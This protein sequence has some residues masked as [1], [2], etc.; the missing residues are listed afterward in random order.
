M[1]TETKIRRIPLSV[2]DQSPICSGRSAADAIAETIQLAKLC[3][4]WGYHRYWVAEHHASKGLAGCSPEVLLARLGVETS[5]IRIGSGGVMLPHYSPYKVAENFKLLATM[6]PG[7]VD[8][9]VGRAPGSSQY[10]SAALRYGSG[11]D[12]DHFPQ[13]VAD[14]DALLRDERPPTPAMERARAMPLVDVP[15]AL[16]MLGSSEESAVLAGRMGLPYSVAHFINPHI[17]PD[18]FRIYQDHFKPG[19][20]SKAPHAALAVFMVCAESEQAARREALCRDL[21]FLRRVAHPLG[22]P[23]PSV[24]E[25]ERHFVERPEDRLY[26]QAN[27]LPAVIGTPAGVRDQL[28]E[29]AQRFDVDELMVVSITHDFAVRCRSHELLAAIW[30]QPERDAVG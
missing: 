14:L 27:R 22:T 5:R 23:Y 29:M 30:D 19:P 3:E 12:V 20:V 11:A 1:T 7:R 13:M 24:E 16:W 17:T 21:W 6:Y 26:I 15:P 18:I 4:Q 2:L 28:L 25:V 9:G 8:L 10:I